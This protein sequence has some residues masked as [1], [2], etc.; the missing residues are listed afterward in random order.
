MSLDRSEW[1]ESAQRL[2]IGGKCR[3]R[4]NFESRSNLMLFN[5]GDSWSCWCF[6]CNEG[7]KVYKEHAQLIPND[8]P[9]TTLPLKIP[10]DCRA[11][12]DASQEDKHKVYKYL[13]KRGLDPKVNMDGVEVLVSPST[14]RL[15]LKQ[16]GGAYVGRGYLGQK[17]KA[18]TFC[19][20]IAPKYAHHPADPGD[21]K[22]KVVVLTEDYLSAL[23]VRFAMK[24]HGDVVVV[25]V[26]GSSIPTAII[27]KLLNAKSIQIM[28]DGDAP[29]IAGA[30]KIYHRLKGLIQHVSIINTPLGKD[31]KDLHSKEIRR[32]L[33][34]ND[35]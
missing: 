22:D 21:F 23:K 30:K 1:L 28:L 16:Q 13:L 5:N 29:G 33:N 24:E 18:L 12:Q 25:S 14:G 35:C 27:P 4:H 3:V 2:P 17:V 34:G 31:P 32:L 20:G 7:G 10:G 6:A 9:C 19:N 11:L 15:L 26:Q 8:L